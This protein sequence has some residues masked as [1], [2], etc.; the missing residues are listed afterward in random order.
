[1]DGTNQYLTNQPNPAVPDTR[2]PSQPAPITRGLRAT[3]TN[4]VLPHPTIPGHSQPACEKCFRKFDLWGDLETHRDA[5]RRGQVQYWCISQCGEGYTTGAE[6]QRHQ[7]NCEEITAARYFDP[8]F[9]PTSMVGVE[10]NHPTSAHVSG[11]HSGVHST[12]AAPG[13]AI[14]RP[15]VPGATPKGRTTVRSY[16]ACD[17]CPR[18]FKTRPKL[19]EHLAGHERGTLVFCPTPGCGRGYPTGPRSENTP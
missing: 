9:T 19:A 2:N 3:T 11:I 10:S 6:L 12:A 7:T 15:M 16:P 13:Q 1:M 4:P 17:R 5:H 18:D 14:T 8:T